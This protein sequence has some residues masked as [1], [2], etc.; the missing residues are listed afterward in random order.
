MHGTHH[1]DELQGYAK[2]MGRLF[3]LIAAAMTF[4]FGY[5]LGGDSVMASYLIGVGLAAV[6]VLVAILLNFVDVA[7]KSG[8]R[9]IALGL[10]AFWCVCVGAEYFSH[11]G[12]TVG[13]RSSDVQNAV[14]QDTKYGDTRSTVKDLERSLATLRAKHDWQKSYDPPGAYDA[15]IET[16]ARKVE[17]EASRKGCK[18]KCLALKAEH[19]S[20]VA[21]Q[22]IAA[23]RLAVSEEIKAVEARL[24]AARKIA[25]TTAKGDSAVFSQTAMTATLFTGSLKP[26]EAS[27]H[28][29]GIG[30]GAFISL[31]F[32]FASAACNFIAFR[33][34]T[35]SGSREP[36]P[37]LKH[38]TP[39]P[40]NPDRSMVAAE[41]DNTFLRRINDCLNRAPALT[42]ASA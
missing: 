21:E 38:R 36:G 9:P 11:V 19:A 20:L 35:G 27:L 34:W 31:V 12:F 17:L 37:S 22:A 26:T 6:T 15:R 4:S 5:A 28:W 33:D 18:D 13:H 24:M 7:W 30:I 8:S 40:R 16:A 23:D 14:L 42:H 39:Y 32:T 1:I 3:T 41:A 29:A 2:W 10:A 25:G